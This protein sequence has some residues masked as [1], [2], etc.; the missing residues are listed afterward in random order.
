MRVVSPNFLLQF[1]LQCNH[2]YVTGHRRVILVILL[3][4]HIF[5]ETPFKV[6]VDFC[7]TV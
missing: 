6:N 7:V 2:L 1:P 4:G 3:S 5:P